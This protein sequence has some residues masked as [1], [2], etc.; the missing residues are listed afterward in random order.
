MKTTLYSYDHNIKGT[1]VMEIVPVENKHIIEAYISPK[2]IHDLLIARQK[3]ENIEEYGDLRGIKAKLRF[4][5]VNNRKVGMTKGIVTY[6]SQNTVVDPRTGGSFYVVK[7]C[8][9]DEELTKMGNNF[10]IYD[11]MQVAVYMKKGARTL[12]AL[13]MEPILGFSDHALI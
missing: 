5:G 3:K 12:F 4:V 11:G 13:L 2:D 1:K 9:P 7:I 8:I 10:Q 6:V